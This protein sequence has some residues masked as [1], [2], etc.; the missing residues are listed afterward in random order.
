VQWR[1]EAVVHPYLEISFSAIV[2]EHF[3][4]AKCTSGEQE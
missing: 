4:G 1:Q 3:F 2:T